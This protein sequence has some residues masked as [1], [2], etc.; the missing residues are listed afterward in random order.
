LTQSGGKRRRG[1]WLGPIPSQAAM[2]ELPA[3][4][5]AAVLWERGLFASLK[6]QG[7]ELDIVSH[8]PE[9]LWPRGRLSPGNRA[10]PADS[11]FP[12]HIVGHTN[13][14][15]LRAASLSRAY[16][17]EALALA[18]TRPYEFLA[19]FNP[20]P[21][22]V[23]AAV[24]LVRRTGT[25][26]ISF[27]LDDVLRDP[28]LERYARVTRDAAGHV[29]LSAAAVERVVQLMP[30]VPV[31]HLDGAVEQWLGDDQTPKGARHKHVVYSGAHTEEAGMSLLVAAIPHVS[32]DVTFT[33][34]GDRGSHP[35]LSALK[36]RDTRVQT[37]GWVSPEVLHE[38]SLTAAAFVNPRPPGHGL[39]LASFPSKLM[40]YLKYGRPV[41]STW[42]PGLAHDYEEL[43]VVA[44]GDTPRALAASV[45]RAVAMDADQ[46]EALRRRIKAFLVPGH[47]WQTQAGRFAD[48]LDHRIAVG[49]QAA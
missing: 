44:D 14:P 15:G 3:L 34:T 20:L 38:I 31:L 39:S 13:A 12:T 46:R 43:L 2:A 24:A 22:H 48:F 33:I 26:W 40:S 29:I 1:L 18:A 27:L 32:A 6:A 30:T 37:V 11:S 9:P 7:F 41:A 36:A 45:D 17:R 19:T 10:A 25:P 16:E 28:T 47:L 8:R 5:P 21:W 35:G 42:T 23:A 4:S 49:Q